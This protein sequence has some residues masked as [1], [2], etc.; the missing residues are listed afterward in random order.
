MQ[1]ST[2]NQTPVAATAINMTTEDIADAE[3]GVH[4]ADG[5]FRRLSGDLMDA[6]TESQA[7]VIRSAKNILADRMREPGDNLTSA[8]DLC[9]WLRLHLTDKE[10]EVFWCLALVDQNRL[11][12]A[13]ALFSGTLTK[14]ET[15]QREICKFLLAHN[16]SLRLHLTDKEREV[17]WCLALDDQN[18]LLAAEA[19]F[20]GTLTKVET[21][22]REICKFL[23]AHNA[24]RAIFAHNHPV[25]G[26]NLPSDGDW[27]QTHTL[28]VTLGLL[29]I[30][31]V[32][33][34][35]VCGMDVR[36]VSEFDRPRETKL[37]P[38]SPPHE[39]RLHI[40]ERFLAGALR[41]LRMID[42]NEA[43]PA[44]LLVTAA[45]REAAA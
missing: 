21:H 3:D 31:L 43:E 42:P 27:L 2:A 5:E 40:V 33:H 44:T 38:S 26:H 16:A 29:E 24:S 12:A 4:H 18:R 23:L 30:D 20:S 32:D 45:Y 6:M 17:F 8:G 22:Q 41:Y 1:H 14:V 19:L 35:I 36:R 25:L 13:E 37:T 10:R 11:L 15:H 9:D 28:R 34:L 39:E 7:A